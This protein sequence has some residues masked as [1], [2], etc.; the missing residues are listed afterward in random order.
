MK[1]TTRQCVERPEQVMQKRN[2]TL[3]G[4]KG[5]SAYMLA[6]LWQ[7]GKT[8]EMDRRINFGEKRAINGETFSKW[9]TDDGCRLA[10]SLPGW[11]AGDATWSDQELRGTFL[12]PAFPGCDAGIR[13]HRHC[14]LLRDPYRCWGTWEKICTLGEKGISGG[15]PED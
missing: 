12:V 11:S 3:R 15:T 1:T 10:A 5:G 13:I 2:R 7:L 9:G 14:Y 4:R 6:R 8:G